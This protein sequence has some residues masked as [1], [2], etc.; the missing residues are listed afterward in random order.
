MGLSKEKIVSPLLTLRKSSSLEGRLNSPGQGLA[1]QGYIK[2]FHRQEP[3][4]E[5][6]K[7]SIRIHKLSLVKPSQIQ[8]ANPIS[9]PKTQYIYRDHQVE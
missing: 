8:K 2:N 3:L 1:C 7:I 9:T 5:T 4:R 6:V